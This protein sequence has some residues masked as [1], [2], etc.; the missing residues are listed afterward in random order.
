MQKVINKSILAFFFTLVFFSGC[1]QNTG[2]GATVLDPIVPVSNGD[3]G[4]LDLEA[5]DFYTQDEFDNL[6]AKYKSNNEV[7]SKLDSETEG[8]RSKQTGITRQKRKIRDY[9]KKTN[10]PLREDY[11]DLK[12]GDDE[13]DPERIDDEIFYLAPQINEIDAILNNPQLKA[14]KKAEEETVKNNR[15][16]EANNKEIEA[17]NKKIER[18]NVN[19]EDSNKK[20][21]LTSEILTPTPNTDEYRTKYKLKKQYEDRIE[22]LEQ[23]KNLKCTKN[24]KEK[25]FE[26]IRRKE[27]EDQKANLEKE[28]LE[29]ENREKQKKIFESMIDPGKEALQKLHSNALYMQ[30]LNIRIQKR[31]VLEILFPN[32]INRA[33]EF[34][35]T[36]MYA[37][38]LTLLLNKNKRVLASDI[39]G[40][41]REEAYALLGVLAQIKTTR[42][43]TKQNDPWINDGLNALISLTN[44]DKEKNEL[45]SIDT[46]TDDILSGTAQ[47]IFNHS[48][49]KKN[50]PKATIKPAPPIRPAVNE[51]LPQPRV[52]IGNTIPILPPPILQSRNNSMNFPPLPP[53]P[54]LALS[55]MNIPPPP[56]VISMPTLQN[57]SNRQ[58][59]IDNSQEVSLS[60]ELIM[61]KRKLWE[62]KYAKMTKDEK[63]KLLNFVCIVTKI[64]KSNGKIDLELAIM[65][66]YRNAEAK[67]TMPI[68]ID[69]IILWE[70]STKKAIKNLEGNEISLGDIKLGDIFTLNKIQNDFMRERGKN[71]YIIQNIPV[72]Y[73][74]NLQ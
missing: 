29:I 17:G 43:A 3:P 47:Q 16:I 6:T 61:A 7:L 67:E 20:P 52:L 31:Q 62:D 49:A 46:L 71:T 55:G 54:L 40:L 37:Y 39:S 1:H 4:D 70:F 42:E 2:M 50:P 24:E 28:R 53:P 56:P 5:P 51:S 66:D 15:K 10:K 33:S 36:S 12:L 8:L 48:L 30:I 64:K 34:N 21:L 11:E 13:Y 74:E 59:N 18:E 63:D 23:L 41:Y 68:G 9:F 73:L 38:L 57:N 65:G 22:E 44:K 69:N 25:K 72:M 60:P 35:Y 27:I 58:G 14:A 26:A 19:L 45:I 32:N